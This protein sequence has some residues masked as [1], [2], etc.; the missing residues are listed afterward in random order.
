[1]SS[2][3]AGNLSNRPAFATTPRLTGSCE[4]NTSAGL[5]APSS[6]NVPAR[7]ALFAYLTSTSTPNLDSNSA[8]KSETKLSFL[9]LYT[10][11][12]PPTSASAKAASTAE[13]ISS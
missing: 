3:S 4:K 12:V 8:I 10:T 6:S 9:P 5:I 1:M 11:S 7:A 2:I 13:S